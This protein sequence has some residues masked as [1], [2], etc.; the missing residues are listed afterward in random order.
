[1]ATNYDAGYAGDIKINKNLARQMINQVFI[2]ERK[3]HSTVFFA[4]NEVGDLSKL[5]V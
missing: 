3:L 4:Q 2:N 5:T 1:L